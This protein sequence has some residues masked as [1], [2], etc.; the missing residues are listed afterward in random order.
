MSD[1]ITVNTSTTNITLSVFSQPNNIDVNV[2]EAGAIWGSINGTITNQTDLVNYINSSGSVSPYI[3]D[4]NDTSI[5]PKNGSNVITL[6]GTNSTISGGYNNTISGYNSNINGGINN[7]IC[8]GFGQNVIAGGQN[9]TTHSGYNI[10]IGGGAYN[11]ACSDLAVIGGGAVNT[12]SGKYSIIVGG[13][14]NIASNNYTVVVGGNQ[15]CSINTY[16][17]VGGGTGNTASGCASVVTGG[18]GNITSGNYSAIVGGQNNISNFNNTVILGSNITAP[19]PNYTY[20][21]NLSSQGIVSASGGD[22]NLWNTAYSSVTSL[23][24]TQYTNINASSSYATI[25]QFAAAQTATSVHKGNTVLL[26]NGRVY[27]F[28]GTDPTNA[29]QYVALNLNTYTPITLTVPLS[30]AS[31]VTIDSFYLGTYKSSKY[32]LQVETNY[33]NDVYYSELNAVGTISSGGSGTVSEYG[34]IDTASIINGYGVYVSANTLYLQV[35]FNTTAGSNTITI[36]GLRSNFYL[37]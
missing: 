13:G 9:N 11:T 35:Y 1:T 25:Q 10:F 32:T 12:A 15:N 21:N 8:A 2:V 20:V 4:N 5:L 16:A 23:S 22:S 28:V 29:N 24:S 17:F 30:V 36:K 33:N 37:I 31:P 3:F 6:S 34:Q 26:T 7:T 14:Y 18:Q 19:Q 27:I